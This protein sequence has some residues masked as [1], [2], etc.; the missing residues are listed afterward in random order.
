MNSDDQSIRSLDSIL[1]ENEVLDL[2]GMKKTALDS[3]RRNHQLP[4]C[5]VTTFNRIYFVSDILDWL[6]SRRKVLNEAS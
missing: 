3:L 5:A 6:K 1:T 2:F 4:F